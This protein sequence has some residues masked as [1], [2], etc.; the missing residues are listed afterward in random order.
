MLPKRRLS[1]IESRI[2]AL[3]SSAE[4][5]GFLAQI[6]LDGRQITDDQ[7]GAI[8]LR[9]IELQRAGK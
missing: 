1:T 2:G 6:K 7:R 3:D 4:V 9:K 8:A 5:D